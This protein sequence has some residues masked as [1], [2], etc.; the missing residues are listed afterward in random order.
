MSRILSK[1]IYVVPERKA[2]I[3]TNYYHS[4]AYYWYILQ[5]IVELI[6]EEDSH[7][8]LEKMEITSRLNGIGNVIT[9]G[10]NLYQTAEYSKR[11]QAQEQTRHETEMELM[12]QQHR[13]E[14]ITA[15][16]TY[17]ISTF[18]NIEQY[19]QELNENLLNSTKDAERDMVDQR[20]QQFQTILLAGTIMITSVMNIL[21]QGP[22]PREADEFSKIAYSWT[23]TSSVFFIGLNMLLCIQ[24]I[25]RVTQFMYRRSE[26]NLCQ[27][28][29]AMDETRTM[30][31]KI[32]GDESRVRGIGIGLGLVNPSE[33][34]QED[35]H[36][37]HDSCLRHNV[38]EGRE[39]EE[40]MDPDEEDYINSTNLSPNV[41][42]T[43]PKQVGIKANPAP[44]KRGHSQRSHI[45]S[46]TS[47]QVDTQWQFHEA[48]VHAYLHRRSAMNERRE[49]L[50]FGAISFEHF[51]NTSCRDS[52]FLALVSFYTGTSM[53]L[54]ATMVYFWNTYLH[55]Y[56]NFEGAVAAVVTIGASLV[57]CLGFAIYLRF[58]DPA[59]SNMRDDSSSLV[60]SDENKNIKYD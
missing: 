33:V 6:A 14:L 4:N 34:N 37:P 39:E 38:E 57:L 18:T 9:S 25:Y 52:G 30:M 45:S 24:L 43:H 32:R 29:D 1:T 56:K 5:I 46:L 40:K 2:L 53:M 16:Q 44:L 47:E 26:L 48:E 31:R 3:M 41:D 17:L 22:L 27:L 23:N 54:L 60:A 12:R 20:S 55:V 50:R 42:K 28:R 11:A 58:F 10:L 36:T 51:W 19:C 21:I 7:I 59:I 13:Q 8:L 15:K 49:V 35:L